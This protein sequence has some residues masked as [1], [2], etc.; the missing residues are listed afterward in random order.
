[1]SDIAQFADQAA[2]AS[3]G[4]DGGGFLRGAAHDEDEG[5]QGDEKDAEGFED[6]VVGDHGGFALDEAEDHGSSLLGGGYCVAAATDHH[7]FHHVHHIARGG[8]E[9]VDVCAED[10]GVG[11]LETD[12]HGLDGGDAD[13]AAEIADEI[14]EAG[15]V[16]HFF[17][18][19]TGHGDG[20][21]R[22]ED[23]AEREAHFELRPEEVPVTC[24]AIEAGKL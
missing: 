11:L 2:Y 1:M 13:A 10:V 9:W 19:D 18:G 6:C 3:M 21:E 14:E 24:A 5:K 17:F 8:A 22:D 7:S 16:A 4:G 23:E 20:G 15:S 12:F